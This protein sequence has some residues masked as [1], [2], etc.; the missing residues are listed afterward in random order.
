MTLQITTLSCSNKRYNVLIKGVRITI[1]Y[2]RG[3]HYLA[4][5]QV[6]SYFPKTEIA[7]FTRAVNIVLHQLL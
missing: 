5:A 6:K 2:L 3:S 4:N 7:I 1:L